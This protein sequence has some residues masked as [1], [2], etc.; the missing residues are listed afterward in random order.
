MKQLLRIQIDTAHDHL[1]GR[2][3]PEVALILHNLASHF[4]HRG[5]QLTQYPIIQEVDG[6]PLIIVELIE[7]GN[8][9]DNWEPSLVAPDAKELA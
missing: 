1:Q 7:G 9:D 8:E 6:H 2:Q 3:S 5:V 4:Q